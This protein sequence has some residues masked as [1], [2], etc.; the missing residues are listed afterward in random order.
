MYN[1]NEEDEEE[2][3]DVLAREK[4]DENN[5][6]KEKVQELRL[7]MEHLNLNKK[8]VSQQPPLHLPQPPS[9]GVPS[10]RPIRR[11]QVSSSGTSLLNR[12]PLLPPVGQTFPIPT[13]MLVRS[14]SCYPVLVCLHPESHSLQDQSRFQKMNWGKLW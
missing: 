12:N 2:E 1:L 3:E 11:Q 6:L 9:V 4:V 14:P 7:R 13:L 8:P 5:K 10:S